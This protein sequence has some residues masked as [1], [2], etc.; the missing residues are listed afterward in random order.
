[1][2]L[3]RADDRRF[4]ADQAMTVE[5]RTFRLVCSE[6]WDDVRLN[7]IRGRWIASADT[8]DGPTLGLG[9]FPLD[10]LASALCEFEGVVDELL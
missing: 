7:R 2:R 1:M 4:P 3:D 6:F 8:S 9:W 5:P 10:A